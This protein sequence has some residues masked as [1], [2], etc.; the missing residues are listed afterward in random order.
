[1]KKQMNKLKLA[2]ETLQLLDVASVLGGAAGLS[3]SCESCPPYYCPRMPVN[4]DNP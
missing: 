4:T 3:A 2:K 1:M